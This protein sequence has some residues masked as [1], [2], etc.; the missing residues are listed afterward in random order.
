M[1][2]REYLL[3]TM[4]QKLIHINNYVYFL[5]WDKGKCLFLGLTQGK[6]VYPGQ[7]ASAKTPKRDTTVR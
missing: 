6:K 3:A 4:T 7:T 5:Y 1:M 2:P